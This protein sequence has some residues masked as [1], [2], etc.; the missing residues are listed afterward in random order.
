MAAM[1]RAAP[2][3]EVTIPAGTKFVGSLQSSLSTETAR[4]GDWVEI[5]TTTSLRIAPGRV[6][7]AG[8]V[9]EGEVLESKDAR[10]GGKPKL[11]L[12]FRRLTVEGREYEIVT[13]PFRVEGKSETKKDVK[14]TVG[15]AVVGGV[16]GAITGNTKR[17]ILIGTAAGAAVAV[18]T[19][20]GH[21][22]LPAGQQI[23]VR[24]VEPVAVSYRTDIAH[25]PR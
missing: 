6:L 10:I 1:T 8:L 21:I 2:A 15:G 25:H 19:K 11:M 12:D 4:E 24:L 7:P 20:G 13:D 23:Q 9:L 16:L 22:V 18:A 14:R 3:R 17:G 5:G